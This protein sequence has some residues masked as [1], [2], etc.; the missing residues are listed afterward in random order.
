[1]KANS[2]AQ[3]GRVGRAGGVHNYK[4]VEDCPPFASIELND[5]GGDEAGEEDIKWQQ[6]TLL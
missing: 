2:Q 5:G 1:M 6:Q 3:H 4:N